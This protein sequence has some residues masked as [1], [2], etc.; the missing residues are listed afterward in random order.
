LLD[1]KPRQRRYRIRHQARLDAETHAK[2]EELVSALHRKLAA[3][4]RFVISW[5]L[6]HT[7]E[8][9]IDP[10]IPDR[11]HLMH[12]LVAPELLQQVQAAADAHE[13]SVAVWMQ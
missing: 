6:A 10:S 12:I 5:G 9:T 4:L 1:S 2:L 3:I 11:L 8:W 13:S 7:Q